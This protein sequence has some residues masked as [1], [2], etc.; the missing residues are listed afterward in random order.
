MLNYVLPK[1][2]SEMSEA[3]ISGGKMSAFPERIRTLYYKFMFIAD[4]THV[5]MAIWY[6]CRLSV[7]LS[8]VRPSFVV[9]HECIVVKR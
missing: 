9:C 2:A 3:R 4:R 1:R 6:R 5:T 7:C 8:V